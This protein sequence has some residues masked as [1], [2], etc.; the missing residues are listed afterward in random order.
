MNE[1]NATVITLQGSGTVYTIVTPPS[2]GI[3][4]GTPP[5]LTYVPYGDY[6]GTDSFTF[7]VDGSTPGTISIQV[8]DAN[9]TIADVAPVAIGYRV[10]LDEDTNTSTP[11][12]GTDAN[13]G[14][15]LTYMLVSGPTNGTLNAGIYTPNANYNGADSFTYKANDGTADSATVT[16]S[17]T[18]TSVNDTPT[19]SDQ[20]IGV[21]KNINKSITLVA[22]DVDT[23][24]TLTYQIVTAPTHGTLS[25]SIPNL[26]YAPT[27]NYIGNDSF[28]FKVNDG[29][30]DSNTAT[31]TITVSE[32]LSVPSIVASNTTLVAIVD[33]AITAITMNESAGGAVDSF[34]ITPSLPAG[35]SFNTSTGEISGTTTS[36][37]IVTT[38]TITAT[39]ASG[40]DSETVDIISRVE[41]PLLIVRIEF[42]DE[43]F[44]SSAAVWHDKIY[45]MA[46][47]Q[48][49]HYNNEVL[50]GQYK[51]IE[52]VE[53]EGTANDGII[54]VSL[55]ENHPG[56]DSNE[57]VTNQFFLTRIL[58]AISAADAFID[59]SAYDKDGNNAISIDELQIMY[60]VAG[61]ESATGVAPGVWAHAWSLSGTN[62]VAPTHDGVKLME[63]ATNGGYSRF[64]EKHFNVPNQHDATMGIIAHELGHAVFELPDLYDTDNTSEG[65]GLFGLMGGGSWGYQQGE[66]AG[67]TPVHMTGWAKAKI[68]VV[69][70]TVI[71]ADADF[72]ALSTYTTGFNLYK[73]ETGT[74]GE[75]FL[76]ENRSILGYDRG[77]YLL[78]DIPLAGTFLGGLMISHIDDNL[79]SNSNESHKLVDIEEANNAGLDSKANQ[80]VGTN[81]FYNGNA[82]SFTNGT[83]PNS[84]RYN[85]A[86]TG[87]SVI[88]ISDRGE[89]MSFT[90]QL[91]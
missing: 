19:A 71:N 7:T 85:G 21:L 4:V 67:A 14:T 18:V 34:S 3:L 35:L 89:T 64:G 15:T 11:F 70:P 77:L 40:T 8:D 58:N 88:S 79:N 32:V 62:A 16:V 22:S 86:S 10:T 12:V 23:A 72:D 53:T 20:N 90:I 57:L 66:D 41:L 5:I 51:Y 54:T 29:T 75:Y 37:S 60:L 31:V 73:V 43:M 44:S 52:A 6:N 9:G 36:T 24:D 25:G 87:L 47:G 61:G 78:A 65:I 68:G 82:T 59:F 2:H 17:I 63:Y 56:D 46:Q 83:T 48:L 69:T 1:D 55:N 49:N 84:R 30:I 26:T 74:A 50:Y 80:G 42:N 76:L 81:L 91:P 27:T 33:T 38:Y 45:G 13:D 39:N 28:T